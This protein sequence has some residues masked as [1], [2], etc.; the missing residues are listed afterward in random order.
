MSLYERFP[1]ED[2]I[3][4]YSDPEIAQKNAF[5]KY[6][7]DAILYR[8]KAKN[9]KYSIINP[10]GKIVNFGQ[11]KF[12]DFTRTQN[13][14]NRRFYLKR[15]ANIKGNWRDDPYSPNNLSRSILWS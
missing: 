14:V 4:I 1:R 15:T 12:F 10:D 8:S 6:G 13:T 9:K 3:W 5:K 2:E 7:P 11:M